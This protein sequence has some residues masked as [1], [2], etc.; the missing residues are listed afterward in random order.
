MG[1]RATERAIFDAFIRIE[2]NFADES[3]ASWQ[4]PKDDPPD[5]LCTTA[6]GRQ[7]GVELADWVNEAQITKAKGEESSQKALANAIGAQPENNT[8]NIYFAQLYSKP[9]IRVS[10]VDQSSFRSEIFDLVSSVD[11][12]WQKHPEWQSHQ[13][14]WH[15]DFS[16]YP[17]LAK[18]LTK[19]VF[20]SRDWYQGVPP[21][22]RRIK[23]KWSPGHDWLVSEDPR[24]GP[25]SE[26]AMVHALLRVLCK[27]IE[28]YEKKP[29]AVPLN[30][31]KSNG[32]TRR[33]D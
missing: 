6:T 3:I 26:Q 11:S 17:T 28:K 13:G 4:Q 16:V 7:I 20:H 2:P 12:Q 27:K 1:D 9:R 30:L 14:Y 24:G 8:A 15:T 10:A 32:L 29:P 21:N 22:G 25:Y 31:T 23:R 19:I 5:V 18:H 33:R